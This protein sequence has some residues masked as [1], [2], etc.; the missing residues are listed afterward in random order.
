MGVLSAPS[1]EVWAETPQVGWMLSNSIAPREIP[2]KESQADGFGQT[3]WHE[4]GG[5]L[6]HSTCEDE[7]QGQPAL[8]GGGD[9]GVR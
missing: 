1:R 2:H 5:R 7:Q 3:S 8:G 6:P 9:E 4:A